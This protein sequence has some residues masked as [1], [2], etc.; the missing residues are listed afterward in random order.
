[1]LNGEVWEQ[2]RKDCGSKSGLIVLRLCPQSKLNLFAAM[3]PSTGH[4]FV[5]LTTN[6]SHRQPS[7]QMPSGR[8]FAVRCVNRGTH[9]DGAHCL[10]LELMDIAFADVFDVIGNDVLKQVTQ[11]ADERT[12]FNTFVLQIVEWQQF[13]NR[14]Q[15]G[16]FSEAVQQGLFGELWFLREVLLREIHPEAAV[17]SWA[18]PKA[19]TKDFQFSGLAFEVKTNATKQHGY[20]NISSELQLDTQG[21]GRLILFGL[22]MEKLTAGGISL[23][24]QVAAVRQDLQPYPAASVRFSEL[25]LQ[26]GYVDTDAVHYTVRYAIRTQHFFDV[27]GDFPR[28]IEGDLRSGVGDVHYSILLSK[29]E[30]YAVTRDDVRAALRSAVGQ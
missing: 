3:D 26:T 13:L 25:L 23:P 16:G 1:M 27:C 4:R 30:H 5:M 11:C 6:Q 10:Q 12:A 24:E 8:G 17:S 9:P 21:V 19:Q 2:L 14:L 7:H 15:V 22:L 20:F 28:I 18:G 29:C